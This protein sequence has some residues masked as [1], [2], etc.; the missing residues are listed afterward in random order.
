[1]HGGS[2]LFER[3]V[4]RNLGGNGDAVKD[5]EVAV[6]LDESARLVDGVLTPGA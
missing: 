5:R 1:M 2:A 4:D 3:P 6:L